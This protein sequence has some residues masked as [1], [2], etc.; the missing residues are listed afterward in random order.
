MPKKKEEELNKFIGECHDIRSIETEIEIWME[1][2]AV[3]CL[4][5]GDEDLTKWFD[6]KARGKFFY[7]VIIMRRK[8]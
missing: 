1:K 5:H 3:R 7:E 4:R 2:R 6:R 8:Q